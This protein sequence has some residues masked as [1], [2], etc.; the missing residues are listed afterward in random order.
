MDWRRQCVIFTKAAV[1]WRAQNPMVVGSR[2][3][4]PIPTVWAEIRRK[5]DAFLSLL[6]AKFHL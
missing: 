5:V 1:R 3:Y 4:R 2:S 6:A